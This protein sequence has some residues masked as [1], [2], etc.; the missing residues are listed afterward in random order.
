MIQAHI[1][2][3][4]R[5]SLEETQTLFGQRFGVGQTTVHKWET[6]GV[7]SSLAERAVRTL[8]DDSDTQALIEQF[9]AKRAL[10]DTAGEEMAESAT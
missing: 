6:Q 9:R 7:K 3:E 2:K 1:V 8:L 5:E 4:L 10:A